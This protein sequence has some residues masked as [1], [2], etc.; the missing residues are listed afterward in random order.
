MLT[1]SLPPNLAIDQDK[2]VRIIVRYEYAGSEYESEPKTAELLHRPVPELPSN[3]PYIYGR[4]IEPEEIEGHFF[5]RETEQREVLDSVRG[6]QQRFLY[7]EGIRHSGKS[8]LL[9]SIQH[10]ISL[11]DLPFV[12]VYYSMGSTQ[13]VKTI[14]GIISNIFARIIEHPILAA[15]GIAGPDEDKC[16]QN[17]PSTYSA[18]LR[19]LSEA[20]PDRK[21][22]VL[23]DEMHSLAEAGRAA[24]DSDPALFSGI[25][26]LLNLIRD[27]GRPSAALLWVF[28]GQIA[29]SQFSSMVPGASLWAQLRSLQIDFL[30]VSAA[31]S[32][33]RAPLEGSAI[34]VPY[35][36]VRRVHQHTAGH[37]EVMQQIAELMLFAAK[38]E[39]RTVLTPADADK[40]A[41]DLAHSS[42]HLFAET[43]YPAHLLSADQA[44]LIAMLVAAVPPG[45]GIELFRLTKEKRVTEAVDIAVKDLVARKIVVHEGGIIKIKAYVLDLWLRRWVAK[46]VGTHHQGAPAFF[47]DLANLTEGKGTPYIANLQT[48]LGEGIPGRFTWPTVLDRIDRYAKTFTPARFAAKWAINYPAGSPAVTEVSSRDYLVENLPPGIRPQRERRPCA[49]NENSGY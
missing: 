48:K 32:I 47:L 16:N 26:G 8:S 49:G 4:M 18:F 9:Q 28:A 40:A 1:F 5:G 46:L 35:E 13:T 41:E 3:S 19:Q 42:D 21:I 12:P 29:K 7:I 38:N 24:R 20:V 10:E 6:G 37:P 33:I 27:N 11:R 39:K 17:M 43:W 2:Q 14:G 22:L 36:T 23:A 25:V 34:D 30:P 31:E 45:D 15:K 44:E